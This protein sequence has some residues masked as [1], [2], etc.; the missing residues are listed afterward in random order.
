MQ[1]SKNII[2]GIFGQLD[3]VTFKK[4]TH[5]VRKRN[6]YSTISGEERRV[7]TAKKKAA[8]KA[9]ARNRRKK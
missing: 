9:R 3:K 1:I 4:L 2:N 5:N 6:T 7:R 8:K